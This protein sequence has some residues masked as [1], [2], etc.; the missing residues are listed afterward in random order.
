[1][2]KEIE[3]L[4]TKKGSVYLFE[5]RVS[6][7][8]YIEYLSRTDLGKQYPKERFIERIERLVVNTQISLIARDDAGKMIGNCFG[9][10]D[11]AYWLLITDLGIDRAY[12]KNGIGKQ[13]MS[14]ARE[15]SGGQKD[16]IVLT[17][18]NK[19]AVEFYEKIGMKKSNQMLELTDVEWTKFT[20]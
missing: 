6:A 10:T 15:L 11:Y 2:S 8:E 4:T 7:D 1:L 14:A 18:A 9:L 19:N 12:V 20:V 5:E 17:Y 3:V 13:M 16:I